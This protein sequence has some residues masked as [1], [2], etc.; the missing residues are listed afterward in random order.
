MPGNLG[1]AVKEITA[2]HGKDA[3][4]M[5]D[6]VREV[7]ARFG[8]VSGEAMELI[9]K[10][11][12]TH[13]VEVEGVVSFYAFLS[14]RPLGATVIR[15][16]DCLS[17][18]LQGSHRVEEAFER[19]L[20]IG[21]GETTP[22]GKITLLRTACIGLCDQGPAALVNDV[23]VTYLS[24]DKVKGIVKALRESGDPRSLV[25]TLGEGANATRLVGAMVINN[26]RRRGDVVFAP[27][28]PGAAIAK[29]VAMTPTE[30]IR[31]MKTSRLRG[32]GGA[33][34][35]LGMKWEF[36]RA[37][38]GDRKIVVCN[39][40]EGEPGTFKDRVILTERPHLVVEGMTIGGYAV[41]ASEGIIYLRGEY[42]YLR[43]HI[44]DLLARRREAGLLG[45]GIA[46]K[47]GFDFD[48]RVQMGAGAY[49]CGEESALIESCEGKRGSPRDR[50]PFPVEKGYLGLPTTVNN[51]ETFCCAAR[52]IEKGAGWFA[53]IGSEESS[54]TK[55]FSVSGDCSRPGVYE[56]PFGL[57]VTEFLREVGGEDAMA[58]QVGGPSG[59]CVARGSF[60]R[61]IGYEDLATGGSM[62]VFGPD[63]DILEVAAAFMEFFVEESCGYCAPCRVGNVLIKERVDRIR[64]GQGLPEDLDYLE[65]LCTTVKKTSRCGLGQTSPNP[66]VTTLASFRKAYEAV[67]RKS[68]ANGR[69][70]TFDLDAA[71][72]AAVDVQGREPVAHGDQ[73][74]V[75]R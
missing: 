59:N 65:R 16:S 36:A 23:P 48:V 73:G 17:G 30:V 74:G 15:L 47:Q 32:R 13:R 37:A 58:V 7:Q 45:K 18:R 20:G 64:A 39:A 9:A 40:D 63:R 50:P 11:L 38:V 26:I 70:P 69:Q 28:E 6:V 57:S 1:K 25:K 68:R 61:K 52:A 71:L 54:G 29:A 27:V 53:Q 66:V 34:F 22:D 46:G 72:R 19:E 51:V 31:S 42:E 56:L 10:E 60:G 62:M 43:A 67:L 24:T 75:P 41:G 4:R 55:L 2:R 35:P 49:V 21:V 5:M 33:G 8:C 12:K 44:E 14:P 3:S